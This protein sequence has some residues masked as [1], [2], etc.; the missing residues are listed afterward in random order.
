MTSAPY[1]DQPISRGKAAWA[2][3]LTLMASLFLVLAGLFQIFQ[4]VAALING[5]F[6]KTTDDNTF[7]L[8]SFNSLNASLT[9]SLDPDRLT[10]TAY[11]RNLLN[12]AYQGYAT[13]LPSAFTPP[14]TS[15]RPSV[16]AWVG[17]GRVLGV[18]MTFQF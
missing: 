9:M 11:G 13:S 16:L 12:D 17:E 6:F 1:S 10:L 3:G 4:G 15:G 18:E 14:V 5:S 8:N 7:T 2:V